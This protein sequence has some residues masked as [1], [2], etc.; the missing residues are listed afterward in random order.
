VTAAVA[1]E[2]KIKR[3]LRQCAANGQQELLELLLNNPRD[4]SLALLRLFNR[5]L[6]IV[7][8]VSLREENSPLWKRLDR[9]INR[10]N[11]LV[12]KEADSPN[13]DEAREHVKTV[14][15]VFRWLDALEGRSSSDA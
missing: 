6:K 3:T 15:D 5:P 12:H 11:A 7:A 1:C 10:R 14:V 4:W 2:V 8:G 9:L 13:E